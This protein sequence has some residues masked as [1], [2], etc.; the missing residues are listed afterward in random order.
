MVT[1]KLPEVESHEE[2]AVT[3]AFGVAQEGIHVIS[4]RGN[5][6]ETPLQRLVA[7]TQEYQLAHAYKQRRR[8]LLLRLEQCKTIFFISKQK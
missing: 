1:W 7:S 2:L 4:D 8:V 3:E 5:E 6:V